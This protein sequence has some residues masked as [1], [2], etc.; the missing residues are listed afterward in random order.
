VSCRDESYQPF[1]NLSGDPIQDVWRRLGFDLATELARFATLGDSPVLPR[2]WRRS[3]AT[4]APPLF[5]LNGGVRRL[6]DGSHLRA[7]HASAQVGKSGLA[8]RQQD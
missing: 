2:V 6:Q 3:T 5:V 7:T 4:V 1:E 8:L